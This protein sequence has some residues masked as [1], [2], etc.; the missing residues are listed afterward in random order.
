MNKPIKPNITIPESFAKNGVKTDFDSDLIAEGFDNLKPDVL[1]GDNLNKFIDDTYQGLNYG[2]AAADAINLINEGETLTVVDG[3][4]TSGASGGGLEIGDIGIAPLGIDE[5]KG[6]R[7]YLNGQIVIQEQYIQFTNKLKAAINLYPTLSCSESDWQATATMTVGGQ[8]G[9]FVV[10]NDAGTIRLPKI[11]MPIQGLTDLSKLGEIVEAGL[12]NI[13]GGFSY[14]R[15][16]QQPDYDSGAISTK[17]LSTGGWDANNAYAWSN[18]QAT[19]NASSYNPI[20]GNSDTVQEEAIQYP[21]FIQ[22]ATGSETKAE[23]INE[24]ELNNPYSFGD[25]KYSPVA[26]N[27]ISWLKSE[28]QYNPKAVYTDYY[29]WL[30]RIYN[31]TEVVEGVSVKLVTEEYTD[32]DWVLNTADETFRLPLL[33]GSEDMP[34]DRYDSLTLLSSQSTYTAPANGWF[35]LD[36][37]ITSGGQGIT[38]TNTTSN[39]AVQSSAHANGNSVVCEMFAKK[40][41][42]I[43]VGYD[44]G[45]STNFFRF[46]YAQGNGSLYYYVGETVQNAHLINAG[47]IQEHYTTKS[48]VDG[49]W[50]YL[51]TSTSKF[52]TWKTSGTKTFDLSSLLPNDGF[53]Y[54]CLF[55]TSF[56][57]N[58]KRVRVMIGTDLS[59]VDTT[60]ALNWVYAGS[61]SDGGG[62]GTINL[63]VGLGRYV[64]YYSDA[65][66]SG[67]TF[68]FALRGY[69]RLGTNT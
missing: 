13:E 20:Y 19:L 41:D 42:V 51:P 63:A 46:I 68:H 21:Y 65:A 8:V 56:Y 23:I 54:E 26:L 31:G 34:S 30:L 6:K 25:S 61:S 64:Q 22:V 55:Q 38:I 35:N 37:T 53:N 4:L 29:D 11:I 50:V 48:M 18:R 17:Q 7:R 14:A 39:Q 57:S 3:K 60:T 58:S 49:Q 67:G 1:A 62:S 47:R 40:G 43:K 36:K 16:Y 10:D 24:I 33:D 28:G 66:P 45:G 44:A 59:I 69:R 27:N 12:P 5:T 32:Y 9:K 2:M 15:A 52:A